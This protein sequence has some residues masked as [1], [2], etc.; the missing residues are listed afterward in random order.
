VLRQY[1]LNRMFLH[2]A[3]IGVNRPAHT[4]RCT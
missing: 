1:G 4:N 2:A 3:S